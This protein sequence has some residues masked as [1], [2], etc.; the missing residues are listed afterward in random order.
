MHQWTSVYLVMFPT[1]H[2]LDT[3]SLLHRTTPRSRS[4]WLPAGH[5]STEF[6]VSVHRYV[7]VIRLQ[8]D[9]FQSLN[10]V[11]H[12]IQHVYEFNLGHTDSQKLKMK[13]WTVDTSS[14]I[15]R[16]FTK[17]N[18]SLHRFCKR[19][20]FIQILCVCLYDVAL[21]RTTML[22]LLLLYNRQSKYLAV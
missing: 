22:K 7:T 3:H 10:L 2:E 13:M 16:M 17:T 9:T 4:F 6:V 8:L 15:H 18:T 12:K 1:H 20:N 11:T 19:T 21:W 14:K 5:L